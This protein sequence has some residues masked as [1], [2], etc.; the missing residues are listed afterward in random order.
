MKKNNI[1]ALFGTLIGLT[2]AVMTSGCTKIIEE[3]AS[4]PV[5]PVD[6]QQTTPTGGNLERKYIA[7]GPYAVSKKENPVLQEFEKYTIYYPTSL[8]SE[9]RKYPVIVLCNGSGTPMSKYST[10]AN[11]F[12]SWGFIVIG[13][14]ENYSW[15]A[16]GAEMSLCYLERWNENEMI[17]ETQSI[18]YQKV[19]FDNVGVVGHSQGGIGVINAITNTDHKDT[20]KAAVSL[21]PTNKELANNLL[22]NYDATKV[23]IPIM[24]IAGEG[25]GDDWVLTLEQ[26]QEIYTDIPSAKMMARRKGTVHNEVLYMANGYVVAWFMWQLQG[27]TEAANAFIGTSPEITTNSYYTDTQSSL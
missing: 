17:E 13:T 6:Y 2:L 24:L 26:M 22:W 18:F 4:Q 23:D 7:N 10:V 15:N 9:S 19:D 25:G 14:E 11:H 1:I 12:A 5:A 21:S 3:I 27:D 8:E 20:Y 16:F